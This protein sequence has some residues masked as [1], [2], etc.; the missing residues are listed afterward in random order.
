MAN[1]DRNLNAQVAQQSFH[2]HGYHCNWVCVSALLKQMC[3]AN[4][5]LYLQTQIITYLAKCKNN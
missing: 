4:N 1:M 2:T 3:N 5:N